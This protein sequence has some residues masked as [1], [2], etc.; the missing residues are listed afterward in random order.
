MTPVAKDIFC[1]EKK[2][3]AADYSAITAESLGN[4]RFK[5][6]YGLLYAYITGSMYKGISSA[7]MLIALGRAGSMG[8]L[9]TG[10]MR[11]SNIEAAIH[12]VKSALPQN[13]PY[14]LNLLS[15]AFSAR[16]MKKKSYY[17][18]KNPKVL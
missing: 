1:K 10:G 13:Q 18:K 16:M 12:T 17:L 9:G 6:D 8:Y 15:S 7:E 3:F 5:A 4:A 2:P 14:G 11:Y